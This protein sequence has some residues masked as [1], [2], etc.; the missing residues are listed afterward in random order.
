MLM[1]GPNAM[2]AEQIQYDSDLVDFYTEKGIN[3]VVYNYRGFGLSQG[4][5]TIG[6]I[7]K[8]AETVV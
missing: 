2:F 1:C 6:K 3:V 4:F 5:P 7:R 8:D